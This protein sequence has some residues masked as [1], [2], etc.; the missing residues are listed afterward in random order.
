MLPYSLDRAIVLPDERLA[1][2]ESVSTEK[3]EDELV[4]TKPALGVYMDRDKDERVDDGLKLKR[5]MTH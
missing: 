4:Y 2:G 3:Q 5:H 1:L